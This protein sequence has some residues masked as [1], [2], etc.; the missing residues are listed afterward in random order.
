MLSTESVNIAS[1]T[2]PKYFIIDGI[3]LTNQDTIKWTK[4]STICD[5]TTFLENTATYQFMKSDDIIH[6]GIRLNITFINHFNNERLYMC[7]NYKNDLAFVH[8]KKA[9]MNI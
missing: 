2:F 1:M 4:S 7:Y 8:V 5:D 3:G 9:Y 6:N